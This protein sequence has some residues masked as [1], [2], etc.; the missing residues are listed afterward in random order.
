[1]IKSPKRSRNPPREE[2]VLRKRAKEPSRPSRIRFRSQKMRGIWFVWKE[3]RVDVDT[4]RRP[5][6]NARS[7]MWFGVM[8]DGMF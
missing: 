6:M 4:A 3:G 8:N 7:V 2:E 5:E 1:M